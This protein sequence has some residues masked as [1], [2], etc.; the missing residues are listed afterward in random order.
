MAADHW[1]SRRPDDQVVRVQ[2][3]ERNDPPDAG[4][5]GPRVLPES[6]QEPRTASPV[7]GWWS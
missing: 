3:P 5:E 6:P 1:Q 7:A 4:E 2:E